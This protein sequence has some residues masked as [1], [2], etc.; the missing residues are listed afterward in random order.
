[1]HGR[2]TIG[3]ALLAAGAYVLTDADDGALLRLEPVAG[4]SAGSGSGG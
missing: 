4:E 3:T 2:R 1:M